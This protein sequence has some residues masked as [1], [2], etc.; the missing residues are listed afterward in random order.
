MFRVATIA[1]VVGFVMHALLSTRGEN[2]EAAVVAHG[3]E[4]P[5]ATSTN[6]GGLGLL[7]FLFTFAI[8]AGLIPEAI[9]NSPRMGSSEHLT[10]LLSEDWATSVH[11][12]ITED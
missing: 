3:E 4:D 12:P 9:S 10:G 11:L 5:D 1:F 6:S 7:D 2:K 8:G